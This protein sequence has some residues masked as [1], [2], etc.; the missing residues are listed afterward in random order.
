M[1]TTTRLML[2]VSSV[3]L[4]VPFGAGAA[5]IRPQTL[6]VD[7]RFSFQHTSLSVDGGGDFGYT[8]FDLNAGLGYFFNSRWEL[9]GDLIIDHA[10]IDDESLTDF[11]LSARAQ[12]HVAAT[13]DVIPFAAAGLGF[14][15]HGGDGPDETEFIFP[16][17]IG[18][19]RIPFKDIVSINCFAGYR[20]RSSALGFNDTS[21]NEFF[22]GAGFSVFL[23]GGVG[24]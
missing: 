22:L 17:L 4:L 19:V 15:G 11:G 3:V 24:E 23:K 7:A 20:H 9:I 14:V 12:Y 1:T 13:G 16:E 2:A 21:G 18:G 6:E 8:V 5:S 10:S